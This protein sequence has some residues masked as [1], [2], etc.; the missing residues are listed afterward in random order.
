MN[1][2]DLADL[3]FPDAKEISYYEEK[4]PR[5]NL[6]EGAIVTR[7]APSPTGVMHIGGLYQALAAREMARKTGGVFFLRIEDTDQKR[8][9]ENGITGIVSSLQDFDMS[10]DEGQISDT[11]EIGNYG[12]YRQS[13]RKDIYQAYAK[14]MIE[15]GKA[16]PCFAT[17]EEL[18]EMRAKQEA[19]KIRTGY[20]GVWAKYRNLS[21]EEAIE[22]IKAG[23]PYIVRFKSP[24]R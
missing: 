21:V 3:I 5:R 1:Y 22:K 4:Y 20:Y 12:P 17:Q 2:K 19:A 24:G 8:E 14:Y 10:P 11:E 6:P 7:F 23:E 9:V 16:Y 13:L 15:Q 18:D